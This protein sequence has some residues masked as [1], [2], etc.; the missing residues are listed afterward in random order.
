MGAQSPLQGYATFVGDR[1]YDDRLGD[2]SATAI[3]QERAAVAEY[4]RR[5]EAID[6]TGLDSADRISRAV[7]IRTLASRQELNNFFKSLPVTGAY[8]VTQTNGPQ[9]RLL[10]L[11]R[12]TRFNTVA[13]YDAYLK[14]LDAIPLSLEQTIEQLRIGAA[15]GWTP[16]RVAVQGVPAQI[17]AQ[18]VEDPTQSAFFA[19][20]AKFPADIPAAEREEF[21]EAGEPR[22]E[23][24]SFR[25]TPTSDAISRASICRARV[26]TLQ[27]QSHLEDRRTTTRCCAHRQRPT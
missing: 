14:R 13:D 1:R 18:V 6:P 22:S 17:G 3:L 23:T 26:S 19:P 27:H 25:P 12:A 10:Q 11:V 16:P 20:F 21:R 7:L 15:R 5:A 24:R 2:Q 8:P 4:L 9:F